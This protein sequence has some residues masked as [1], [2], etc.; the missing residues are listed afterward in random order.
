MEEGRKEGK[1]REKKK[2]GKKKK[3]R[4]KKEGR[5]ERREEGGKK[6]EGGRK[7]ERRERKTKKKKSSTF[8]CYHIFIPNHLV[9]VPKC[10]NKEPFLI[11]SRCLPVL[12][13]PPWGSSALSRPLYVRQMQRAL[14]QSFSFTAHPRVPSST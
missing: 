3:C 8:N 5:K 10:S 12:L 6:E 2:E 7:G 11:G 4:K 9:P 14:A 13:H 1:C